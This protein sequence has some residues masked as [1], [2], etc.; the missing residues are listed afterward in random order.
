MGNFKLALDRPREDTQGLGP[1]GSKGFTV[2]GF[3]VCSEPIMGL[4]QVS[5]FAISWGTYHNY[6]RSPNPRTSKP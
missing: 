6:T 1:V 3:G 2:Q 4:I 5:Q